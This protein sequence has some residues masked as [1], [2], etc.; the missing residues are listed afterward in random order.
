MYARPLSRILAIVDAVTSCYHYLPYS[1]DVRSL[2][3]AS[4]SFI[5]FRRSRVLCE[6]LPKNFTH[7]KS[8]QN[9]DLYN[10]THINPGC[11]VETE[12]KLA[13]TSDH[14]PSGQMDHQTNPAFE[15]EF[16]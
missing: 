11:R 15:A 9:A 10:L 12:A 1:G 7:E 5:Y 2:L 6:V 16:T 4:S 13:Q 14:R 8:S 3:S